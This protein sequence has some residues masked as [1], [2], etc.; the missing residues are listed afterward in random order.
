MAFI[1]LRAA[2]QQALEALQAL[3]LG[4]PDSVLTR[5]LDQRIDAL[6]AALAEPCPCGDRPAAQCP[7]EWEP[8]C[9]LGNNPAYARRVEIQRPAEPVGVVTSMVKGG[10]TWRRW[11]AD[12]PDGTL[13][14]SE[15]QP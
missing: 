9:D 15:V 1:E 2:A 8:N 13:L 6:R 10:V 4:M 7:G 14:F 3:R 5:S 11:P 12:M